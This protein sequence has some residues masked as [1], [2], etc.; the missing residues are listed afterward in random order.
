[1][2]A[3]SG[4]NSSESGHHGQDEA[5]AAT[6]VNED[7]VTAL[8]GLLIVSAVYFDGRAHVL[9]LPDSFF[10]PWH[11]F[12]YGGLLLLVGWLAVLGRRVAARQRSGRSAAIP[13]GYGQAFAGAALFAASGVA[14]MVWHQVFGVEVG[15]EALLSPTHLALFAG[16]ALLFSGPVRAHRLR[17]GVPSPRAGL[18]AVLSVTAIAAVAAF[19]LSYLSGFLANQATVP[20]PHAPAGT[21]EHMVSEAITSA[22]LA[23]YV[24]TSLVIVV[25]LAFM[26]R[27]GLAV[28]G[29]ATFLVV[30]LAVLASVLA[31]FPNI[32]VILAA[33]VA[34]V[35]ADVAL[36]SLG[37]LGSSARVRELVVAVLLPLL[38]WPGQ[39]L[40]IG[41][42][43]P[44]VWSLEIVTGLVIVSAV[45]SFA[46]VFVLPFDRP[47][48]VESPESARPRSAGRA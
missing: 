4:T 7:L 11:A 42:K 32:G 18:P 19:A 48:A 8:L 31:D 6:H 26:V 41:A 30:A 21:A 22:G 47:S 29:A 1:M 13:S 45:M 3:Q 27:R 35:F 23:S 25:P 39:L 10:T 9:G 2:K 37:R 38:L 28:P 43:D 36:F 15:I 20:V 40:A 34:G 33:A 14:D 44:I 24:V 17:L 5:S 12:L 46:A 16:G